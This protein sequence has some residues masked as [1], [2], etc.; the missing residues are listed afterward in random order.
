MQHWQTIGS[1]L[2]LAALV[3]SIGCGPEGPYPNRPLTIVC[4][5]DRGGGTDTTCRVL[6]ALLK[7]EVGQSV[8]V[9][10]RTG[11]SGVTGHDAGARARPD[12]YTITM[13]TVEISMLHWR[14]LAEISWHDFQPVALLNR[15]ASALIVRSDAPWQTLEELTAAIRKEPGRYRASGTAA[16]GVWHLALTGWLTTVGLR[17]DAVTWIPSKGAAPSLVELLGGGVDIITCSLPE[18]R[19]Q[20]ADGQARPLGVMARERSEFYPDV[21]TFKELGVDWTLAGWRGIGLPRAAP[22]EV[23][24]AL[25]RIVR[26]VVEGPEY[27]KRMKNIGFDAHFVDRTAYTKLLAEQDAQLGK[28]LRQSGLAR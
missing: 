10:N 18:A 6:A 9:L 22:V 27:Q 1:L 13:M 8:N 25:G 17:P 23:V 26:K 2:L 11:G 20:I 19:T 21:P 14:G 3:S 12:G 5:W 24:E 15:E 28:L 16:G 4:P 7:D